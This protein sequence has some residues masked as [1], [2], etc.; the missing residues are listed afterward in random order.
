VYGQIAAAVSAYSVVRVNICNVGFATRILA[1]GHKNSAH[2][3]K[4]C[5]L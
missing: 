2:L 1:V 5:A 3:F 4:D